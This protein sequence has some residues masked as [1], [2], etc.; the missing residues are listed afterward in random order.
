MQCIAWH[1]AHGAHALQH[2]AGDAAHA[3]VE[4]EHRIEQGV[5]YALHEVSSH[6]H[7]HVPHVRVPH[8]T[9]TNRLQEHSKERHS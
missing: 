9:H 7:V 1:M 3:A 4:V 6:V 8:S 5:S 2:G